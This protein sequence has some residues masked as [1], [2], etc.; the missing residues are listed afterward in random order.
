MDATP[1]LPFTAYPA[2]AI[3]NGS[4]LQ[5]VDPCPGGA[6][7]SIVYYGTDEDGYNEITDII[8]ANGDIIV[9]SLDITALYPSGNYRIRK[10]YFCG[11]GSSVSYG[12]DVP[13][14]PTP[15]AGSKLVYTAVYTRATSPP[16]FTEG[17]ISYYYP[18]YLIPLETPGTYDIWRMDEAGTEIIGGGNIVSL[19]MLNLYRQIPGQPDELIIDYTAV[20]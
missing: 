5:S 12:V 18:P 1:D 8:Q 3:Q 9:G 11:D 6:L 2:G 7:S 13:P 20:P 17:V 15:P 19:T 16:G 14:L 10:V 4:L